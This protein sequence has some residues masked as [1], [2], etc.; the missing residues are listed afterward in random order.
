MA[1]KFNPAE[2]DLKEQLKRVSPTSYSTDAAIFITDVYR[3][4]L[5]ALARAA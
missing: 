1:K 3:S 5:T 4:W 2:L